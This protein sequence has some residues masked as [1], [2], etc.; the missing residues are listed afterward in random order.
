MR[1]KYSIDNKNGNETDKNSKTFT[2]KQYKIIAA[3]IC[4]RYG[5]RDDIK[6]ELIKKITPGGSSHS[7]CSVLVKVRI[8]K[9]FKNQTVEFRLIFFQN[10][11]IASYGFSSGSFKCSSFTWFSIVDRLCS[12]T[13]ETIHS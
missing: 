8:K 9:H 7:V 3:G 6:T 10:L 11:E 4:K 2:W 13:L 12:C 1:S 5:D